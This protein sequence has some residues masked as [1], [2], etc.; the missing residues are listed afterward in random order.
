MGFL[1]FSGILCRI[2][3]YD[4]IQIYRDG[5]SGLGQLLARTVGFSMS[6]TGN[7]VESGMILSTQHESGKSN[8]RNGSS[9]IVVSAF[10]TYA[11][12]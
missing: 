1:V 8:R 10:N 4:R 6:L 7:T 3:F 11:G 2:R 5:Y 12:N 9:A